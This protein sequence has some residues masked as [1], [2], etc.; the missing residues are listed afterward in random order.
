MESTMKLHHRFW[1]AVVVGATAA[2]SA[3]T[4]SAD[5][6]GF[7]GFAP[8][9]T[10]GAA[11][12]DTALGYKSGGSSFVLTTATNNEG[13]SGYS[14]TPQGILGFTASFNY[15]S[16]PG[17]VNG[18]QTIAAD[19]ITLVFQNPTD[20]ATNSLGAS[21][22]DLGYSGGNF[23]GATAALEFDVFGGYYNYQG[24]T[25]FRTNGGLITDGNGENVYA[26]GTGVNFSLGHVMNIILS[27]DGATLTQTTTDTVSGA[28]QTFTYAEDLQGILGSSTALV[29]FTGATGG[30]NAAQTI[31]NFTFT[32]VPEPGTWAM[33]LGGAGL[34][35]LTLRRRARQA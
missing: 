4:A 22:N 8:I 24:A 32:T 28:T 6:T 9:N 7:S 11:A 15:Q 34:L 26:G 29:G 1:L 21:G 31:S 17:T 2:L 10:E 12:T 30:Y 18:T 19:G 3:H 5:I 27:Y 33:V 20:G 35:G 16:A 13:I 25:G 14:P 23:F